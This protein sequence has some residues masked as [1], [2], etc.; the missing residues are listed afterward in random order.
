MGF[1]KDV[2]KG[3]GSGLIS[4]A[5]GAVGSIAGGLLS[6][7][8]QSNASQQEYARQKEFAQNGIRWRVADAKAAGIHP[9]Y[10]I[11]ANVSSYSPQAATGTN[12]G[13]LGLSQMGQNI[14]GAIEAK[15]TKA[16]RAYERQVR[17]DNDALDLDYKRLRNQQLRQDIDFAQYNFL[18]ST[19]T[20]IQQR[21]R[22]IPAMPVTDDKMLTN[23]YYKNAKG[24]E[25]LRLPG[26]EYIQ[27]WGDWLNPIPVIASLGSQAY[28]MLF[29]TTNSEGKHW[30]W[31]NGYVKSKLG[32]Q[33]WWK[34]DMPGR[35]R[36]PS[37]FMERH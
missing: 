5:L 4:G 9:L 28:D 16:E 31:K 7:H 21:N 3:S 29:G 36:L 13:D 18:N 10:A 15:Q 22:N 1:L 17:T 35:R 14:E 20:A 19:N 8:S 26:T 25:M 24:E 37:K 27:S 11:G 2:F 34:R 33:P 23:T 12:Y 30:T 6:S 32:Y